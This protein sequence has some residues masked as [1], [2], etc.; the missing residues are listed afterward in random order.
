LKLGPLDR[1]NFFNKI[2]WG[3]LEADH[4]VDELAYG[5]DLVLAS[6]VRYT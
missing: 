2:F 1:L 3:V 6:S 5:S 4:P